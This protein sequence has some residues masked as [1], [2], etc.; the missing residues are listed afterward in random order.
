MNSV[1]KKKNFAWLAMLIY[2]CIGGA[3]GAFVPYYAEQIFGEDATEGQFLFALCLA[4]VSLYVAFLLQMIIHEFG[5]L[6]FGSITG[7]SFSSFRV[8]NL[9][10]IKDGNRIRL[11][12]YSIAGTGGQCLMNPP[13]LIDGKCPTV[14]YNL[15]GSLMNIIV[16]I[17]CLVGCILL[18][19]NSLLS[20][21]L[22]TMTIIGFS[23]ALINGW[24]IKF[25]SVDN[26][27]CN[28]RNLRRDK[29]AIRSF[30]VQMKINEQLTKGVRLKDMPSEWFELP[31]ESK[32]DNTIIATIAVFA[33]NRLVDEH[34]FTEAKSLIDILL[35]RKN[36]ILG[37]HKGLL[38]C[39]RVYMELLENP[40]REIISTL[41]SKEQKKLM[42][43]MKSFISVVRTEY[44]YA[45]LF[46]RDNEKAAKIKSKFDKIANRHPL[47]PDVESET[48]LIGLVDNI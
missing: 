21:F 29:D 1:N 12:K 25:G 20:L 10:W 28:A 17:P 26:D 3:C 30:W 42:T 8:A 6:V 24:P 31:P 43:Q 48:E 44:A 45:K 40:D 16:S 11:K 13:E 15:G 18:S 4:V 27:G 32:M 14:L 22:L 41:L 5:H 34:K 7:Y 46:E 36:E 2:L 35:N 38:I 47:K 39:D 37:L 23:F 9:M 19:E 33:A